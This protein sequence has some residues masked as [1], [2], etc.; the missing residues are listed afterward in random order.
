MTDKTPEQL[1]DEAMAQHDL[2]SA[3]LKAAEVGK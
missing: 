2:A 1:L 3:I